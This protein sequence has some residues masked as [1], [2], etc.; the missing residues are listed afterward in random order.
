MIAVQ[1]PGEVVWVRCGNPL[2][3]V[4]SEGKWRPM[5]LVRRVGGNWVA[6]GL[7]SQSR[8]A[9]GTARVPVVEPRWAG[10]RQGPSY[11]WGQDLT[12]IAVL[13]VGN[14]IGWAHPGLVM[15]IEEVVRLNAADRASLHS[16][17]WSSAS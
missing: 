5:V 4:N 7:T 17:E 10:L 11:L 8:Y 16:A 2:E 15:Q 13:D 14:H 6:V 3:D 9:D 1:S 12:R